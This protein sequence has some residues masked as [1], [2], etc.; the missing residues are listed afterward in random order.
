MWVPADRAGSQPRPL[1]TEF[2]MLAHRAVTV[3]A[4]LNLALVA[5]CQPKPQPQP[6][7]PPP[8]TAEMVQELRA[9]LQ[10]ADPNARVGL[11]VAVD[12]QVHLAAVGQTDLSRYHEGDVVTF[13]DS[14]Q[15]T[16]AQGQ[17]L[18]VTPYTVQ[19]RYEPFGPA[20]RA[21]RE[22]DIAVSILS[23]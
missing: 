10:R 6:A 22:G 16:V 9:Q 19:V 23:R 2:I 3:V 7:P 4:I 12:E 20:A 5:G 8:A 17:V 14:Q 11:V 1:L 15:R 18:R 21:P 13:I